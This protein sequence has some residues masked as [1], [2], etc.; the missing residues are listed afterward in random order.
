[1]HTKRRYFALYF[2]ILTMLALPIHSAQVSK[3]KCYSYG[4]FYDFSGPVFSVA[5]PSDF[6]VNEM[7]GDSENAAAFVSP[8]NVVEFYMFFSLA[9]GGSDSYLEHNPRTEKIVSTKT[10][11]NKSKTITWTTIE[12]KNKAYMRSYQIH[13]NSGVM[14]KAVG[15]RYKNQVIYDEYKS[16]YLHF[17]KSALACIGHGC[18]HGF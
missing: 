11:A 16:K 13:K 15:I 4:C 10:I 9:T 3:R 12:E 17:K 6:H 14:Y 1:M 5:Y 2:F 7:P 18:E 8:D